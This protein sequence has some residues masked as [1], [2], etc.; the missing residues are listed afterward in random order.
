M[1]APM[2]AVMSRLVTPLTIGGNTTS[3]ERLL[4]LRTAAERAL[5]A[6]VSAMAEAFR[7][8]D[9]SVV[10]T[11]VSG[12]ARE[13]AGATLLSLESSNGILGYLLVGPELTIGL[14]DLVMGGTGV[15]EDREPT[16]LELDLVL[17]RLTG[18]LRPLVTALAPGRGS[19]AKVVPV[20][21][22]DVGR[23]TSVQLE[24]R[25]DE[26][27]APV[28]VELLERQILRDSDGDKAR[29]QMVCQDV[30]VD[31][32]VWLDPLLMRTA[33]LATLQPGDVLCLDHE[34]SDP[35]TCT[36]DGRTVFHARFGRH[37]HRV[38]VQVVDVIEGEK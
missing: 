15:I 1:S 13:V 9:V 23:A 2:S 20:D 11:G 4:S 17:G 22:R 38:A 26:L 37:N 35:L 31:L 6:V 19:L 12:G 33:D 5:P 10:V 3:V 34:L 24:V 14:A 16:K 32:R 25:F 21:H 28:T 8:P 30:A 29:M 36:V 27:V 7:R 18:T